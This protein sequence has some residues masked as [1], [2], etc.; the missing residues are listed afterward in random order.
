V[1]FAV[2]NVNNHLEIEVDKAQQAV[3]F[4]EN[5]NNLSSQGAPIDWKEVAQRIALLLKTSEI[6][7]EIPTDTTDSV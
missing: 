7:N 4:I 1:V 5:M 2:F 3:S 6:Q